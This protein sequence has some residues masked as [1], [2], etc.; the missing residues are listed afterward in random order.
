MPRL[1]RCAALHDL[2]SF[3][4]A[5]LTIVIPTLSAMG[6]QVCPVPTAVLSTHSGGFSDYRFV[7]LT[8]SMKGTFD[9]WREL[10]LRFECIYSGFL[11][12]P[13]QAEQI[14]RMIEDFRTPQTLVVIDP[15]MG[16]NGGFYS[17]ISPQM[18]DAMR[19]LMRRADVLTPNLT[20]VFLLLDEPYRADLARE[21]LD[22][23]ILRL[24]DM[25]PKKIIVTS[26]PAQSGRALEC[27]GY[28]S[29]RFFSTTRP[30]YDAHYP[31]TG[32]LFTSVLTGAL[33]NERSIE[34]ATEQAA[35]CVLSLLQ[36][37]VR[38][39][40]PNREG[41]FLEAEL[42]ALVPQNGPCLTDGAAEGAIGEAEAQLR[43]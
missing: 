32:D 12:S 28:E 17:S 11:G 24:A 19:R 30:R 1:K 29:G 42:G 6:I 39:G 37:S 2:S 26:F 40:E 9:H 27:R 25:G 22:E 36:K 41:V 34:E 8:D 43:G 3:G 38:S 23:Y 7:D 20:E 10:G 13:I 31:G 5:S 4:R 33:L 21:E 35:D 18:A 16:D 15:V 14:E